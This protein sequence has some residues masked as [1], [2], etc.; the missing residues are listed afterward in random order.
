MFWP[1]G[2]AFCEALTFLY[3]L[4]PDEEEKQQEKKEKTGSFGMVKQINQTAFALIWH[5]PKKFFTIYVSIII[6]K[7]VQMS[8]LELKQWHTPEFPNFK[9]QNGSCMCCKLGLR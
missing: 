5:E 9:M 1:H 8:E 6:Q 2:A 4:P 3:V 7:T